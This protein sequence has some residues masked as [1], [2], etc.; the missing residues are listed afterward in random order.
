MDHSHTSTVFDGYSSDEESIMSN[1]NSPGR[2]ETE[3]VKKEYLN[4]QSH[5]VTLGLDLIEGTVEEWGNE[6]QMKR[7]LSNY[8]TSSPGPSQPAI[9]QFPIERSSQE[10]ME[11]LDS[12]KSTVFDGESDVES[13]CDGEISLH[14]HFSASDTSDSESDIECEPRTKVSRTDEIRTMPSSKDRKLKKGAQHT[15]NVD[16]FYKEKCCHENCISYLTTQDFAKCHEQMQGRSEPEQKQLILSEISKHSSIDMSA[17]KPLVQHKFVISGLFVCSNAWRIAHSVSEWRFKDCIKLFKAGKVTVTHGNTGVR[18]KSR[19]TNIALAW[20]TNLFKRQGDYMPHKSKVYLPHTWTK[21]ALFERMVLELRQSS[22]SPEGFISYQH[23]IRLWTEKLPEFVIPKSTDFSKCTTCTQLQEAYD[24]A[25]TQDQR[26]K[27]AQL[28]ATH[29]GQVEAERRAYHNAREKARRDPG[30]MTC[31]IIDGMDQSKTDIPHLIV[32][33]KDCASLARLQVHLTG[34]LVHTGTPEGKLPFVFHD[35]KHVPHDCNLT[36]HCLT[37]ALASA[38]GYLGKVLFLQMDNCFRENK[39]RYVLSYAA[40]LVEKDIF[41]EVYVH[42]LP[43]GHTHED[44]DQMFSCVARHLQ[45]T[46]IYTLKDLESE[47]C[48]SFTPSID[49][50]TITHVQDVKAILSDH[51]YGQFGNHSKPHWFRFRKVNGRCYMH[52]K[53]WEADLWQPEAFL[54]YPYGLLCLVDVPEVDQVLPWVVSTLEKIDLPKLEKELPGSYRHRLSAPVQNWWTSFLQQ[55]P[56]SYETLPDTEKWN[57]MKLVRAKAF[58]QKRVHAAVNNATIEEIQ[59]RIEEECPEVRIGDQGRSHKC[60]REMA[61]YVSVES[62][63]L[64]AVH[65][66]EKKGRPFIGKVIK[67]SGDNIVVQWMRGSWSGPWQL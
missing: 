64:V 4:K 38:S 51:M 14:L 39:N 62:G 45:H 32:K 54:E 3:P 16:H 34:V 42:F 6:F 49:V 36:I 15:F 20:M 12:S 46:N 29:D 56:V 48:K 9:L 13:H 27:L 18:R 5:Q 66:E 52:Y 19:K 58:S 8:L 57:V 50:K 24:T 1:V 17:N 47:V 59:L 26:K 2:S 7:N 30:E 65:L 67:R 33:D 40:L 25:P 22:Y 23:F 41:E 31:V 11:N 63:I 28:K 55:M 10:L 60:V 35:L 21:K 61:D 43:V 37:E 44:V 53:K